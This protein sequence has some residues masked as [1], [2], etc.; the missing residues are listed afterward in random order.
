MSEKRIVEI[1]GIK[2]EVDLRTAK[3]I[4]NYRVGDSVKLLRKQYDGY[5]VLP[6]VIIGFV[7]FSKLPTIELLAVDHS[8]TVSFFVF[9]ENTKETEIAPFNNYEIE[10]ER[11]TIVD[12]LEAN[13]RR[14]E[15]DLRNAK[16]KLEAFTKMFG[17]M[18]NEHKE[19]A[20]NE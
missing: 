4:D 2:M 6:A 8:G 18:F 13:V 11:S 7:E 16:G 19:D 1:N 17:R 12:K 3:V 20:E 10:F 14:A 5:N 9:N 15:E